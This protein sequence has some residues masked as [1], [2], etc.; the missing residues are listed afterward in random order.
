MVF[1]SQT[2][3]HICGRVKKQINEGT[4]VRADLHKFNLLNPDKSPVVEEFTEKECVSR[5]PF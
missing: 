1:I 5:K 4:V 3:C 2:Y